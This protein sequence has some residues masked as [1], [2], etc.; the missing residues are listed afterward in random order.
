MGMEAN[1]GRIL[2]TLLCIL[3]SAGALFGQTV[4]MQGRILDANGDPKAGTLHVWS[5]KS[6]GS[7]DPDRFSPAFPI[8]ATGD[9]DL[10]YDLAGHQIVALNYYSPGVNPVEGSSQYRMFL[11]E[12]TTGKLYFYR[13]SVYIRPMPTDAYDIC[14]LEIFV[15]RTPE[16]DFP[17]PRTQVDGTAKTSWCSDRPQKFNTVHLDVFSQGNLI[18][19]GSFENNYDGQE[20]QSWSRRF[21]NPA[22][23]FLALPAGMRPKSGLRVAGISHNE[24][25]GT[26]QT[27]IGSSA[28]KV[29]PLTDYTLLYYYHGANVIGDQSTGKG[30]RPMVRAYAPGDAS[31]I[32]EVPLDNG[33]LGLSPYV[34]T[35][36]WTPYVHHFKTGP[37]GALGRVDLIRTASAGTGGNFYFDKIMVLEGSHT[38]ASLDGPI[39]VQENTT[40]FNGMNR[41]VQTLT[42]RGETDDL[43]VQTEYDDLNRSRSVSLPFPVQGQGINGPHAYVPKAMDLADA[44]YDGSP[45]RPDAGGIPYSAN[46]YEQSPI[47]RAS[48]SN[49]PGETWGYGSGHENEF[50]YSSTN[51]LD[52][53]EDKPAQVDGSA[54]VYQF[55]LG[56]DGTKR[57]GFTD[58][59]GRVV[60]ESV[61][62]GSTWLNTDFTYDA[63]GNLLE[64]KSPNGPHGSPISRTM[65]SNNLGQTMRT[66]SPEENTSQSLYDRHG[67]LRFYRTE[68]ESGLSKFHFNRYDALNRVTLTGVYSNP[69]AF[70]PEM[71]ES[72]NFPSEMDP[73]TFVRQKYFY[74]APPP[75]NYSC[76]GS[77]G[78]YI[79]IREDADPAKDNEFVS[80]EE[81]YDALKVRFATFDTY[82]GELTIYQVFPT[83]DFEIVPEAGREFDALSLKNPAHRVGFN[84]IGVLKGSSLYEQLVGKNY[85]FT[86]NWGPLKGRLVKTSSCNEDLDDGVLGS[87]EVSKLFNYDK[88]GNVI[89][90]FEYNGYLGIPAVTGAEAKKWQKTTSAYD[91]QNRLS[92][93]DIFADASATTPA[94]SFTYEY[95][96]FGRNTKVTLNGNQPV[97]SKTYNAIGQ[98]A[99]IIYGANEV[100]TTYGYHL[101]GWLKSI[102]VRKPNGELLF[103]QAL[104]YEDG[105][106]K[107]FDGTISEYSSQVRN[108]D[109]KN[110]SFVYDEIGRM[111]K[112][113]MSVFGVPGS[114]STWEYSYFANGAMDINKISGQT[115]TY[116]YYLGTNRLEKVIFDGTYSRQ[117][118]QNGNFSYDLNGNLH[119]DLSNGRVIDFDADDQAYRFFHP[120]VTGNSTQYTVY[121]EGGS[122][123]SKIEMAN[124]QPS[125]TKHYFSSG[126]EI[127]V[128]NGAIHEVYPLAGIGRVI[129]NSQ[130]AMEKEFYITDHLGN[131]MVV[132]NSSTSAQPNGGVVFKQEYEPYGRK[133][134]TASSTADPVTHQFTG[135]EIDDRTGLTYFGARY[136]DAELG[137]W[138]S[139]DPSKEF[140]SPYSYH[141]NPIASVDPDGNSTELYTDRSWKEIDDNDPD[142]YV[143]T[144]GEKGEIIRTAVPGAHMSKEDLD[145]HMRSYMSGLKKLDHSFSNE[146]GVGFYGLGAEADIEG[147]NEHLVP[148][149]NKTRYT[150]GNKWYTSD[151]VNYVAVGVLS[152]WNHRMDV[153]SMLDL[154][155]AWKLCYGEKPSNG[156]YRFA[157]KGYNFYKANSTS[158]KGRS[159][160]FWVPPLKAIGAARRIN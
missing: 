135:K 45:G 131:T 130:G 62:L 13:G 137:V 53:S 64:V 159:G 73:M 72:E 55:T 141:P 52:P 101:R 124:G 38:A 75:A 32:L 35:S 125:L 111:K 3:V 26:E 48:Q 154:I 107:R 127:R 18:S 138:I 60:R 140:H 29:K 68:K 148:P 119:G 5:L 103:K 118:N 116:K 76:D 81:A 105:A 100:T 149:A 113:S 39:S 69:T 9:F 132:Y 117:F 40:Y 95:D 57:R 133:F 47:G 151:E 89:E 121:D 80:L 91:K 92:R 102:D 84:L 139:P 97:L 98:V 17:E 1:R 146:Q 24:P 2:V 94:T 59:W 160:D 106:L 36:D 50:Y 82:V 33:R 15:V 145:D 28:F 79:L 8:S 104:K 23:Y 86:V 51:T 143:V 153:V 63:L 120:G 109:E 110:W 11:I 87:L 4:R 112:T 30:T 96:S 147:V 142:F 31:G 70:T 67:R 16:D 85:P 74:D 34:A 157:M 14:G 22:T 136:Y 61:K 56:E 42:K 71:A 25:L 43:I 155:R 128:D 37:T 134:G 90:T 122:R 158:Y 65:E 27:D 46:F 150:Y 41:P 7:A 99:E 78:E 152:G 20:Y 156:T 88:F 54:F 126:K 115:F 12:Y 19:N 114:P 49:S 21:A 144:Y 10:T 93:Q 44:Y 108:Q 129:F 77:T 66:Y 123:V 58:K 6:Y 83:P